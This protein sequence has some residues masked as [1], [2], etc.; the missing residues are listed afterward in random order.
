MALDAVGN[1]GQEIITRAKEFGADL[2]GIARVED[3]QKSPSHTISEKMPHF[4][5]M[6]AKTVEG[7][8]CGQVDWP[9]GAKSAI[10]IALEHPPEKPEL[11]WW[12]FGKQLTTG[13]TPGNKI[14][15]EIV[16]KLSSW[17]ENEKA[18]KCFKLPYYVEMGAVYMKDAA[19]LAGLGCVGMNN[20]LVTPQYGPRQRL[21]VVL[22][23]S[24]LPATGPLKGFDPC[25]DCTMPCRE[26]CPVKAFDEV[27]Y[28]G[29]VYGQDRLPGRTGVYSRA[30]CNNLMKKLCED[31][32]P[33]VTGDA[34][35]AGKM[36]KFCRECEL[37]CPVG[38]QPP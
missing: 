20:M 3:L 13:N 22:V 10:I 35:E 18:V 1:L 28:T 34:Q 31:Y 19:A 6:G 17:L 21:R 25:L 12:I 29:K 27:L 26:A 37:A 15:M 4:D 2:V 33:V 30:R 9:E 36:A 7:R 38:L 16:K 32:E 23:D 24:A 11:D 8:K 5:N 14:L